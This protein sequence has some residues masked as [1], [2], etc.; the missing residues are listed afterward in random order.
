MVGLVRPAFLFQLMAVELV[1]IRFQFSCFVQ[2]FIDGQDL[3]SISDSLQDIGFSFVLV[4]SFTGGQLV[5]GCMNIGQ[6]LY[7][8]P[9]WLQIHGGCL[10]AINILMA[11]HSLR[12]LD[13]RRQYPADPRET[14]SAFHGASPRETGCAFH[15]AGVAGYHSRC[16]SGKSKTIR[17]ISALFLVKFTSKP[18]SI[19][20]ALR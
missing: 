14:G 13:S 2:D 12:S 3:L 1:T 10:W 19:P 15:G 5:D 8:F 9:A 7:F 18:T 6:K 16:P 4:D 11:A 17:F 20:V